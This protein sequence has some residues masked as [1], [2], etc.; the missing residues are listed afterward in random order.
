MYQHA[1]EPESVHRCNR[2]TSLVLIVPD[3][4]TGIE[5]M[6]YVE[7]RRHVAEERPR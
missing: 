3:P 2:E 7:V 4:P 5:E 1:R 6:P